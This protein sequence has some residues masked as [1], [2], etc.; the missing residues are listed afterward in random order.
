MQCDIIGGAKMKKETKYLIYVI[1]I[2]IIG[3]ILFFRFPDLD[4]SIL[5]IGL[6]RYFLFHS[7]IFPIIVF[8]ITGFFKKPQ[9]I[10]IILKSFCGAFS[11]AIGVHLFTDIWQNTAVYFPFIGTLVKGTSIDDRIWIIVNMIVCFVL[12]FLSYLIIW[13]IYLKERKKPG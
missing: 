3:L 4:I 12:A 9:F 5:G 10:L 7:A 8:I 11:T 1:S 2:T 6:H 13:K